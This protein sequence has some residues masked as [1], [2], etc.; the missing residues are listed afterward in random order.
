MLYKNY[1][2]D[3]K[4]IAIKLLVQFYFLIIRQPNNYKKISLILNLLI[5]M[6]KEVQMKILLFLRELKYQIILKESNN[7]KMILHQILF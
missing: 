7:K 4:K 3:Y 5:L 6:K 2:K 1:L